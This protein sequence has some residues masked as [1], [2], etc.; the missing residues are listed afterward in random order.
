MPAPPLQA[1]IA[2][3][4][5]EQDPQTEP[6]SII[7]E[8]DFVPW[9]HNSEWNLVGWAMANP[10]AVALMQPHVKPDDFHHPALQAVIE[11][12][13]AKYEADKPITP[14]TLAL[15]L[16]AN[17]D[18]MEAAGGVNE[19]ENWLHQTKY[20]A[21]SWGTDKGFERQLVEVAR[22]VSDLR[23]RRYALEGVVDTIERLRL[24]DDLSTSLAPIISIA[25][26]ENERQ[27]EQSGS[28][29]GFHAADALLHSIEYDELNG[30]RPG[31]N[32]GLEGL[33]EILGGIYPSNLVFVGGRP[34]MGKS[35]VGT[36]LAKN[37]CDLMLG[38]SSFCVDY[39]SLEMTKAELVGRILCDI[40]Y[41]EAVRQGWAPIHYSR[42]QMRRLSGHERERLAHARNIMAERYPDLEIHD[43]D[44][45]TMASIASLARAKVARAKKQ[46][47]FII[48]HMH[49][50]DASA[51]YAGR[52]VDEIS[53]TTKGAK[54]M[55][56]RL[57]AGVVMLAQLS[58]ALEGREDK[59]P[60]LSDFR[61][62]GSIEQDGD[63]LIGINR[64][65]YFL[66][67]QKVK[68]AE[69]QTKLDSELERTVNLIEFGILKNRHGRI[70][71]VPAFIDVAAG[72]IRNSKP[73]ADRI[74]QSELKF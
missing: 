42:V 62:S 11:R 9:D 26:I 66:S 19:I 59:A 35:I 73:I 31:A 4:M 44:Q 53:E 49:L 58:R 24:G 65:H 22:N 17:T 72:A 5:A 20:G 33:Q 2:A 67:R 48:D 45:L 52:K 25:D 68:T 37:A 16:R 63:V 7:R 28:E 39:F 70:D 40:D 54:R 64:P 56:K 47:L 36:T 51:R 8:G 13:F 18:V 71:T 57:D 23:I 74:P 38:T 21:P 46:P 15:S 32:T 3:E 34:A 41:D 1:G 14:I 50:V 6:L 30:G 43:R 60:Q 27:D 55:A 29:I 69:E 10:M 12:A 61:D